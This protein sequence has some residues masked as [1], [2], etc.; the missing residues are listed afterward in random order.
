M[1]PKPAGTMAYVGV[2]FDTRAEAGGGRWRWAIHVHKA[3]GQQPAL[4]ALS[5][6]SYPTEH[7][8][9][10]DGWATYKALRRGE[11]DREK[12]GHFGPKTQG[13]KKT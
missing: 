8:A 3:N 2:S 11:G 12:W 5:T 10:A 13:K 1:K 4:A 9:R 7:D 6:A